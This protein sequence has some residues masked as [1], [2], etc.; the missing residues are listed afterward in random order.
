MQQQTKSH[1]IA[2]VGTLVF[3]LLLFL[4]SWFFMI[5]VPQ[6]EEDE[7]IMI[8]FGDVE[9]AG[10][11]GEQAMMAS[12]PAQVTP[13]PPAPQP[14]PTTPASQDLMSQEDEEALAVA[15]EEQKRKDEEAERMRR[16]KA[17][18]EA[19]RLAKEK[20]ERDR[21][22]AERLARERA[23][24]EQQAKEEAARQKAQN[25]MGGAFGT[26]SSATHAS[27]PQ[28]GVS[29][30]GNPIGK[31][32]S[33]GNSWSLNGRNL[34]G[35]LAKP[36]V[37]EVQEG[38]VVVAIRVNAQGKVISAT[39]GQGSTV[40]DKATQR[41]ACDAAMKAVFSEGD[42]DVF[43]TITYVFKNI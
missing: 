13:P 6:I 11:M 9:M 36:A 16:E 31:G 18:Q 1:I 19:E 28:Q 40:S 24:A 8:S 5:H 27:G 29:T 7:G 39:P 33:G 22:E 43:G 38:K 42:G 35:Q 34:R 15:K 10:G 4:F 12:T 41:A 30:A 37:D 25:L 17:K 23:I 14:E 21:L 20:A 2:S 3:L 32:T 26:A